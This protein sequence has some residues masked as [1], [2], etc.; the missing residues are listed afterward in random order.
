MSDQFQD[1]YFPGDSLNIS[2]IDD[3]LLDE[4]L[5]GHF[6]ACEGVSGQLDLPEGALPDGLPEQVVSNLLFLLIVL[7]HLV[8]IFLWSKR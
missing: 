1:V 4:Y 5:N 3:L 6:L 8:I 2:Y 7:L